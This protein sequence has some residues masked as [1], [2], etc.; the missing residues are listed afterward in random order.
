MSAKCNTRSLGIR[1]MVLSGVWPEPF[2]AI[3]LIFIEPN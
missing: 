2:G 3:I 1:I